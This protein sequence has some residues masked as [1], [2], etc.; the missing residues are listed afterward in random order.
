[1][2]AESVGRLAILGGSPAFQAPLHVGR[3]NFGCSEKVMEKLRAIPVSG[4]LTN[5]GPRVLEL[6][7]RIQDM[8]GVRHCILVCNGTLGLQIAARAL[9]VTGEVINAT[10]NQVYDVEGFPLPGRSYRLA[11]HWR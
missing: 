10:N 7:A 6:E 4:W 9:G 5:S 11:L 2:R 8:L 3:P 1:M